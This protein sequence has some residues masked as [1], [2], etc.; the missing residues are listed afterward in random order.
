MTHQSER[1]PKS[2]PASVKISDENH[3]GEA[4]DISA[5]HERAKLRTID[6]ARGKSPPSFK[7][8]WI[9]LWITSW[10]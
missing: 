6:G 9:I 10:I 3:R 4:R 5:R 8:L 2:I 1:V 7:I